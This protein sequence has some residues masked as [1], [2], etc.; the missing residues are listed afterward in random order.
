M[1]KITWEYDTNDPDDRE[2][3]KM[4]Q[5]AVGMYLTLWEVYHNVYKH[6]TKYQ[7]LSEEE[8]AGIDRVYTEINELLIENDVNIFD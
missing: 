1:G 7:D 3:I 6:L 4:H 5:N 2:E 8:I